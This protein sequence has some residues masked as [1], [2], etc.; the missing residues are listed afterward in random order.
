MSNE[1]AL[2]LATACSASSWLTICGAERSYDVSEAVS[3]SANFARRRCSLV[4]P[5]LSLRAVS[6][7]V[8]HPRMRPRPRR[9]FPSAFPLFLGDYGYG[10]E[11]YAPAPSVVVLQQPPLYVLVPPAPSVPPKPE[12]HEYQQAAATSAPSTGGRGQA[13]AIV[14]KDGSV[15]SA[16]A[17]TVQHSALYYVEPDGGHR[18]V[19]LDALDRE[20]TVRLNRERKLQLQL[21][22]P[23]RKNTARLAKAT[24][25]IVVMTSSRGG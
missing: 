8:F 24:R 9:F 19:S 10:Y 3:E 23:A 1:A 6:T 17:V 21:P 15:H 4:R 2:S 13:F 12:I 11:G 25:R 16:V 7:L 14:L 22:Q 18:L 20:A 5:A